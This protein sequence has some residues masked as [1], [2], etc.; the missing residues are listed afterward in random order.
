MPAPCQLEV[1]LAVCG[2]GGSPRPNWQECRH[3]EPRSSLGLAKLFPSVIL[4]SFV[5]LLIMMKEIEESFPAPGKHLL[6]FEGEREPKDRVQQTISIWRPVNVWQLLIDKMIRQSI[7]NCAKQS[8]MEKLN[9]EL[10]L[11]NCY[12]IQQNELLRKKA[13]KLNKENQALLNEL[14]RE[15]SRANSNKNPDTDSDAS[16]TSSSGSVKLSKSRS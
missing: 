12:I 11:Q 4:D 5:L 10:Y 15:L 13:Q 1:E 16:S 3:Q 9:S 2:V 7:C 6:S 8:E 14:K